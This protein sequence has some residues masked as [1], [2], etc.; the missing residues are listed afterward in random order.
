MR[1]SCHTLTSARCCAGLTDETNS[2]PFNFGDDALRKAYKGFPGQIRQV[3]T[4]RALIYV[5][6]RAS[7]YYAQPQLCTHLA[8]HHMC[9]VPVQTTSQ[10]AVVLQNSGDLIFAIRAFLVRWED[11]LLPRK[12]LCLNIQLVASSLIGP[13]SD[14][15]CIPGC[16]GAAWRAHQASRLAPWGLP[17][18]EC[19]DSQSPAVRHYTCF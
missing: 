13:I 9:A 14:S 19:Q 1:W 12:P 15:G 16:G 11:V 2:N 17:L 4:V 6:S 5:V 10:S 3:C 7:V 18:Q 8:P